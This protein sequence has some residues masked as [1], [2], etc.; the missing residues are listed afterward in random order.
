MQRWLIETSVDSG[1]ANSLR[2]LGLHT[3]WE[4]DIVHVT[5]GLP[6]ADLD[7]RIVLEGVGTTLHV[8]FGVGVRVYRGLLDELARGAPDKIDINIGTV[9]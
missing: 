2:Y 8:P 7:A 5:D 4:E 6:A 9:Q 3:N 1:A